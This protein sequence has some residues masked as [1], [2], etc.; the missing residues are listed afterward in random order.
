MSGGGE[1]ALCEP[2]E[3]RALLFPPPHPLCSLAALS[4]PH[5]P[6]R[7]CV[8]VCARATWMFSSLRVCR[9]S[10]IVGKQQDGAMESSQTKG[11]ASPALR[12]G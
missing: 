5:C 4:I 7:V 10:S 2:G 6:V 8:C 12:V 11:N 3:Y 1:R 9:S